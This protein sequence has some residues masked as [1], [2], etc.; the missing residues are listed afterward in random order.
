MLPLRSTL[1]V[2]VHAPQTDPIENQKSEIKNPQN[3]TL[4]FTSS[5]ATLDRFGEIITP[6]GWRLDSYRR[7]PVFQNAH[8]YGDV[9]FTLGKAL[10]TE[11]R[12]LAGR[13][14]LFQRIQFATD[15]N[16]MAKIAHALYAGGFLHGV[17]VGFIPIRW[18]DPTATSPR[19]HLEQEL[20]EVSAVAIPANPNALALALK[21]GALEKSDIQTTLDLLHQSLAIAKTTSPIPPI[22]PT[23]PAL[24]LSRQI[25]DL[26]KHL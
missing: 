19:K 9:I 11:V 17:S 2:E 8:Q 15:A 3:P 12:A 4:D 6:S 18:E 25:R 24:L 7:N 22:I 21:S 20:V 23:S 10:I 1:Q 13:Q 14:V 26:L 16:P 5:D